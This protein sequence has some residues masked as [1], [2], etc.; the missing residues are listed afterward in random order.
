MGFDL[1]NSLCTYLSNQEQLVFEKEGG[2]IM[3]LFRSYSCFVVLSPVFVFL[4][5]MLGIHW[6]R[7]A[8][9]FFPVAFIRCRLSVIRSSFSTGK[10]NG[11]LF[12]VS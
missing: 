11:I 3:A 4:F 2:S 6:G 7:G 9:V 8:F 10:V 12:W 1:V 5:F